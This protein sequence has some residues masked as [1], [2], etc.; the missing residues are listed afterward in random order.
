LLLLPLLPFL[1]LLLLLPPF[2]LLLLLVLLLLPASGG[3][4]LVMSAGCVPK[5][6]WTSPSWPHSPTWVACPSS[7]CIQRAAALL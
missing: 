3:M 7:S 1:L 5:A 6:S 2:L 4:V